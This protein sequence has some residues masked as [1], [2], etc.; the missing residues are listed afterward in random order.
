MFDQPFCLFAWLSLEINFDKAMKIERKHL[1]K[2]FDLWIKSFFLLSFKRSQRRNKLN[3]L[4][5]IFYIQNEMKWAIK[6][7]KTE[8]QTKYRTVI[9]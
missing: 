7:Y 1:L 2:M 9:N 6:R 4:S 5:R 8:N 3:N